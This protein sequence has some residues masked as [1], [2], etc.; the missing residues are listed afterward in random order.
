MFTF[1]TQQRTD[2]SNLGTNIDVLADS[3]RGNTIAV[4]AAVS[5]DDDLVHNEVFD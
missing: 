4:V 2:Y 1:S 5:L 3:L